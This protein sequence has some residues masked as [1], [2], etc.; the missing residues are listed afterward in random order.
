MQQYPPETKACRK[1]D[2]S[3]LFIDRSIIEANA[4]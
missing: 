4:N 1:I 3:L 2:K